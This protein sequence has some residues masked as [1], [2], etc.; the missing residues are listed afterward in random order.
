VNKIFIIGS[1][2]GV[3]AVGPVNAADMPVKA[4]PYVPV[5][6][7]NW[8]GIYVGGHIGWGAIDEDQTAVSSTAA[9]IIIPPGTV[10]DTDRSNFLGGG[11]VGYNWQMG[12]WV[13]G[14]EADFSW[15]D[16]NV[17]TTKAGTL[18]ANSFRTQNA[19][20]NWYATSTG[21]IGYAWDNWLL[22]VKG[23]AA[24]M[25]VN[26]NNNVTALA[27]TFNFPGFTDTRGGWTLGVGIEQALWNNWSWK[28][29]YDYM[30]FGTRRYTFLD[31]TGT[32]TTMWDINTRVNAVT[33]G[34]NYRWGGSVAAKY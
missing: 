13:L 10:F 29:E 27:T 28:L 7:Y 17:S 5:P 22:Y 14:V 23:G 12:K 15:T 8:T 25:N 6:Y 4:P 20:T 21:R 11:Q 1:L 16:A 9:V 26:Y 18:V 34:L 31:T 2:L 24:W 32:I 30:D 33:V 3:F 19:T